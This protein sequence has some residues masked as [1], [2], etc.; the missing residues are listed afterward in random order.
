MLYGSSHLTD[1]YYIITVMTFPLAHRAVSCGNLALR[2]LL[3]GFVLSLV[4]AFVAPAFD[5]HYTER[6]HNHSHVFLTSSA[7]SQGHPDVHPFEQSH[8][9]FGFGEEE[10]EGHGVLYQ[11]SHDVFGEAGSIFF[12]A[13]INAGLAFS[14]DSK[15]TLS[16]ALVATES[17]YP[18]NSPSPP[19]RPPLT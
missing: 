2:G 18:G 8:T 7:A 13:F 9:D 4:L 10:H 6:Q 12:S 17:R 1:D 5:H 14:V 11:T 16:H 3:T 19:T 15:D